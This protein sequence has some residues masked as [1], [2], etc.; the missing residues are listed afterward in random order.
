MS[1]AGSPGFLGAVLSGLRLRCPSC[2]QEP[3]GE[4]RRL[5]Q[6]CGRCGWQFFRIGDGDWLVTWLIAYTVAALVVIVVWPI[7]HFTTELTLMTEM[8]IL[9]VLGGVAVALLFPNCQGASAAILYFLRV[10]WKE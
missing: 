9:A 4:G 7:L 8:I 5:K 2:G 6:A 3:M 10:H 1:S